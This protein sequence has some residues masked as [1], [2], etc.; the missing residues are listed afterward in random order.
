MR[1]SLLALILASSAVAFL[2]CAVQHD[3]DLTDEGTIDES[4]DAVT[5]AALY[6]T[7]EGEGGAFYT[8]TFTKDPAST[9]GG[10]LKGR[11][12]EASIDTGI[13]CITTPCPSSTEVSGVYKTTSGIKL[14]LASYDRPSLEFSR[15]LGDYRMKLVRDTLTLTKYD[16][17]IVESFH[18]LKAH[19]AKEVT[20]AAEAHAWPTRYPEYVYRTFTTRAAA[21]KW[22]NATPDSRWLAR[23]GETADATKFVSGQNDL[24]SQEFTVDKYTLAV[25]ITGEH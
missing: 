24:W 13:R 21:E 16:G 5:L 20:A 1:S 15:V 4:A 19:T 10:G 11:R 3:D 18:K 2:G 8:L 17:T 9:L 25:T 14:T 22:G 12:F 6:G 23:D 7:W